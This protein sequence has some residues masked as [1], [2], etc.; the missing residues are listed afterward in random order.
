MKTKLLKLATLMALSVWSTWALADPPVAVGRIALVQGAVNVSAEVGEAAAPALLNWPVTSHNEISTAPG[1]RTELRIGSTALRLDGDSALEVTELDEGTLRLRL[2]YGSI[3]V[4]IRNADVLRGFSLSTPQGE[5][6]MLEAGR[7][8]VDAERAPDTSVVSVFAGA[9][10][11]DGAGSSI[12]LRAGKRAEIGN[13]NV[14]TALAARDNFDDW[15]ALR[16][17]QAERARAP[18]YVSSELTGYEELDQYGDW[19]DS[20]EYGT[21]WQPRGLPADWVPYRDGSWSWIAPWGWTWVDNAPWGYAPSHYGRWVLVERRWCWAPG[22]IEHH[23]VWAPALVGWVGGGGWQVTFGGNHHAGPGVGWYPLSPRE[24]FVP[25]YSVSPRY[26]DQ[27]NIV[28]RYQSERHHERDRERRDDGHHDGMTVVPHE[29]FSHPGTVA[30]AGLPRAQLGPQAWRGA[31]VGAPPVPGG[32]AQGLPH[33]IEARPERGHEREREHAGERDAGRAS[34]APRPALTAPSAPNPVGVPAA[35]R[36]E[37]ESGRERERDAA[38][39]PSAP[40]PALTLTAPS[41][42]N[43]AGV[44]AAARPERTW[45]RERD[46]P[47]PPPAAPSAA[48]VSATPTPGLAPAAAPP[49]R[50]AG[51]E[52]DFAERHRRAPEPQ[53]TEPARI[54]QAQVVAPSPAPALTARPERPARDMPERYRPDNRAERGAP[55][56][57]P[58]VA[59][60]RPP[61]PVTAAPRAPEPARSPEHEQHAEKAQ[62]AA[63]RPHRDGEKDKSD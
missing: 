22:R 56:A 63:H 43:P 9:A 30:V 33:G 31:P 24:R 6:R 8:R 2:H 4:R 15:S 3:S 37:R 12:T 10:Q 26:V 38:R 23:P 36:P 53:V 1:A 57:A 59:A 34:F 49:A 14:R 5:V 62:A 18:R 50:V 55:V 25:S 32:L 48:N 54:Q 28:V 27:I 52:R 41:A 45:G 58:L 21:L 35:A 40:R 42:P 29:H 13:D 60:P 44:P 61:A 51:A 39:A 46:A 7:I 17:L 11:V 16:D 20:S 47:Q 19:R